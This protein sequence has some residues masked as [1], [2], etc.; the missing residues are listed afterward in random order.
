MAMLVITR[1]YRY[2][3]LDP[4]TLAPPFTGNL[5]KIWLKTL[6]LTRI[7]VNT[8]TQLSQ[9]FELAS[10]DFDF[11]IDSAGFDMFSVEFSCFVF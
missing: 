6:D 7:L 9:D 5:T 4:D 2:Q 11:M 1:G 10:V 8:N 3:E